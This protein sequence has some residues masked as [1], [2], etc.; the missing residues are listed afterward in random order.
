M[1]KLH[2]FKTSSSIF[3]EPCII[4][5]KCSMG[6]QRCF[7]QLLIKLC[8]RA[9]GHDDFCTCPFCIWTSPPWCLIYIIHLITYQKKIKNIA[10]IWPK[11]FS[12]DSLEFSLT[13]Q[14]ASEQKVPLLSKHQILK[15]LCCNCCLLLPS[16][17]ILV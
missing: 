15:A 14:V 6:V 5:A 4:E 2:L 9:C 12:Q 17:H 10:F 1:T 8:M 16:C 3:W 13:N 11:V 7:C